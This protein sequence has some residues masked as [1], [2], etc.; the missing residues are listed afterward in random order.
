M[1]RH[2][3][4][5]IAHASELAHRI[6]RAVRPHGLVADFATSYARRQNRIGVVDE[7]NRLRELELTLGREAILVMVA[8][9]LRLLP[10]ALGLRRGHSL[11]P[12][13]AALA[14]MFVPEFQ[15][16]LVRSMDWPVD[17]L[18]SE[19]DAFDRDLR[20]Y[21][22]WIDRPAEARGIVELSGVSPF[23][24]R[25]ALLLDPSTMEQARIAAEQFENHLLKVA[26]H[27]LSQ[28]GV[29]S[30]ARPHVQKVSRSP[31]RTGARNKQPRVPK[32]ATARRP[33]QT[34][35]KLSAKKKSS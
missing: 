16:A 13:E 26:A 7:P 19:Q 31:R 1:S 21:Q 23:L 17:D 32:R 35:K 2:R 10:A 34:K 15:E 14:R 25:C 20:M 5:F 27:I 12:E 4:L 29:A 24:D 6:V 28:L 11:D 8:E 18:D 3:R 33:I 22:R 9:V 30:T